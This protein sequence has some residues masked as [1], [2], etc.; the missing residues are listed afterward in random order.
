[1]KT[2]RISII[3]LVLASSAQFAKAQVS[4][5]I[6]VNLPVRH[7]YYEP[8]PVYYDPAP[9]YA[10]APAPVYYNR[11]VVVGGYYRPAYYGRRY[12]RRPVV[13]DRVVYRDNYFHG[14]GHHFGRR[15]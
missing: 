1:M 11:P 8:A 2:L 5:G 14:R 4:I 12:Y 3:A 9:V 6:G 13:V 10:P 15:W 7:V